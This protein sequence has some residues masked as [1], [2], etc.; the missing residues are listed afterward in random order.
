[1]KKVPN[2]S[3]EQ[4]RSEFN[5][6]P[7]DDELASS[8]IDSTPSAHERLRAYFNWPPDEQAE[9]P[10]LPTE[11]APPVDERAPQSGFS[12]P[13][14][15][16]PAPAPNLT[17]PPPA[18]PSGP[19][20]TF[21]PALDVVDA[22]PEDEVPA[23]PPLDAAEPVVQTDSSASGIMAVDADAEFEETLSDQWAVEIARLQTLLD[24]LTEKLEWRSGTGAV[25]DEPRVK[26]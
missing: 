8:G 23:P 17:W 6:P 22:Q 12:W 19:E 15:E 11:T 10:A 13:P 26:H 3:S 24:G 20:V 18:E 7:T 4:Q 25:L 14:P 9:Q 21:E 2:R 5:W 1:M 16:E